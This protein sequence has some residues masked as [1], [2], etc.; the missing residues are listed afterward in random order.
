[1]KIKK[2]YYDEFFTLD[3]LGSLHKFK[4]PVLIIHPEQ[5]RH[6]P[7]TDARDLFTA[8]TKPKKLVIIKGADHQLR[9]TKHFRKLCKYLETFIQ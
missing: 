8:A 5:D 6:I 4:G 9:E 2:A 7:I 1:K 3:I